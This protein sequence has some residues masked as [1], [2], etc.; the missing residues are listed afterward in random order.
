[1]IESGRPIL[2]EGPSGEKLIFDAGR[3]QC[4]FYVDTLGDDDLPND[5]L[6][7]E[8]PPS[9]AGPHPVFIGEVDFCDLLDV[10]R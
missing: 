6:L 9:I 2:V 10:L 7:S 4:T 1:V 3:I 8:D 5:I